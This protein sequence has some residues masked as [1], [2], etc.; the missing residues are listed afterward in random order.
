MD[1]VYA[2]QQ[3]ATEKNVQFIDLTSATRD[4]YLQ[5][6]EQQCTDLLFAK[7]NDGTP[8]GTH[9]KTLGANLIAR[10]AAQLLKD[11]AILADYI[12]IPTEITATPSALAIGET[13]SGVQ[14]S[15]EV[16]LTGF[17]LEPETG[18]V[19]IA[20]SGDLLIST[21]NETFA[22]TAQAS[23]EGSTLFQRIYVHA[24]YTSEG[25][26]LDS[27]VIT[28]GA[29]RIVVPV[30]ATVISLAG[31]TQ[32]SAYW[33]MDAVPVAEPV[34]EGPISAAYS[35]SNMKA[36][37]KKDTFI[38]KIV[39]TDT[40][41]V[42]MVR[43]HNSADGSAKTDW[44]AG[45]IDENAVRY[46]DFAVTAPTTMEV[47]LTGISMD[48]L[49]AAINT[50]GIHINTGFGDDF[51]N[52]KTI[53]EQ[54]NMPNNTIVSVALT[55]IVTIPAGETLHVRVLPWIEDSNPRANKYLCM[56]HVRIEGQ[57]FEPSSEDID[58]I[59]NDQSSITNKVLRN[60]QLFILRDGKTFNI[61]G[62]EVK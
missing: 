46:I 35:L 33:Q 17:N 2:M 48:V 31:G 50:M 6:G 39:G 38:E 4:L 21:D 26:Q 10:L 5:Y 41:F 36:V 34:I 44:P 57:A 43:F 25:E 23:Y 56:R 61:L 18:S 9:T 30:T 27:L 37:D 20:V 7:K 24:T 29:K 49:A 8:D 45:E 22:T 58:Q 32:V 3:V 55:P 53:Y 60:G 19:S 51:L 1:Y 52:V 42:T 47:R 16:L 13:Y 11:S 12:N 59:T 28:S 40:T 62:A 54:K 14:Q 15:K